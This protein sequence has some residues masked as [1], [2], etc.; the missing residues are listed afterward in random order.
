MQNAHPDH[1]TSFQALRSGRPFRFHHRNEVVIGLKAFI[2]GGDQAAL[3]LT[4]TSAGLEPGNLLSAYDVGEA[5]VVELTDVVL[6]P[7]TKPESLTPGAG[8]FAEPGEIE[9]HGNGLVFVAVDRL[10]G[11]YLRVDLQSG[12]IGRATAARAA[13]I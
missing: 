8:N 11:S 5:N 10:D 13:E 7:S 9:L 4:R 3:V 1:G 12:A 6:A 2:P